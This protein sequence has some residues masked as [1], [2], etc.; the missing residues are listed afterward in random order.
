M[1][2]AVFP[3]KA[4]RL[5]D[6]LLGKKAMGEG[7]ARQGERMGREGGCCGNGCE[8]KGKLPFG[9]AK[10]TVKKMDAPVILGRR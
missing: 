6:G 1:C 9:C 10:A 5:K 3:A 8:K 7:K 4:G 2:E